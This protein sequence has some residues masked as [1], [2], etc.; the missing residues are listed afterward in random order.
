ML[1]KIV[2][3]KQMEDYLN[4]LASEIESHYNIPDLKGSVAQIKWARDIRIKFLNQAHDKDKNLE[5]L[6]PLQNK[7]SASWW[8]NNKDLTLEKIIEKSLQH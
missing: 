7:T 4:N 5:T 6:L 3:S 2:R 8:I 1:V